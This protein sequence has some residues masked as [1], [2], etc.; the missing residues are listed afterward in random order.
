[1]AKRHFNWFMA[2]VILIALV[3]L[4]I[5]AFSLRKWQRGRMAYNSRNNEV[6][7]LGVNTLDLLN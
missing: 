3:V 2:I 1:M 4:M 5:T 7:S 6:P